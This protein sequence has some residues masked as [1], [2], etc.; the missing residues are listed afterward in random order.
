MTHKLRPASE[1]SS[2]FRRTSLGKYPRGLQ[3]SVDEFKDNN[4]CSP[5]FKICL[6]SNLQIITHPA[7][8]PKWDGSTLDDPNNFILHIELTRD[9]TTFSS[10]GNA[11]TR[12]S[13]T[14]SPTER[15]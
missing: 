6:G 9:Y 11:C 12:T 3:A 1:P 4:S 13:T 7:D 10:S 8:A 2:R 14:R 5:A 15:G